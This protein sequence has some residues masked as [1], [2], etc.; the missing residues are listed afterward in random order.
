ME[1]R[2]GRA[3]IG[4]HHQPVDQLVEQPVAPHAHDPV[5]I[6]EVD[7]RR[8][9]GRMPRVGRH[10]LRKRDAVGRQHGAHL[11]EDAHGVPRPRDGIDQNEPPLARRRG[12]VGRHAV[13]DAPQRLSPFAGLRPG[14][15]KESLDN[16]LAPQLSAPPAA[17]TGDWHE[18]NDERTALCRGAHAVDKVDLLRGAVVQDVCEDFLVETEIAVG[19]L[20]GTQG[21]VRQHRRRT[22]RHPIP[23][24]ASNDCRVREPRRDEPDHAAPLPRQTTARQGDTSREQLSRLNGGASPACFQ[25]GA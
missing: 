5:H 14:V 7:A 21:A 18:A 13:H 4:A 16:K 17:A 10:E 11:A 1:L 23:L 25:G 12:A 19:N 22:R 6:I 8:D 3:G 20:V 9:L 24:P 2:H 15:A